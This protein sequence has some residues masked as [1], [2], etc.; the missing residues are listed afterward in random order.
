[1][2]CSEC[3]KYNADSAVNCDTC[4]AEFLTISNISERAHNLSINLMSNLETEVA[5]ALTLLNEAKNAVDAQ[6]ERVE[7]AKDVAQT[8]QKSAFRAKRRFKD[9]SNTL[10]EKIMLAAAADAAYTATVKAHAIASAKKKKSK[11]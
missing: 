2:Y 5:K 11:Q 1:M 7:A 6:T 9:E 10:T 4:G 3:G 8:L